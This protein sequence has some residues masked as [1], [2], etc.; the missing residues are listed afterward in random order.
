MESK[1]KLAIL[2]M[3]AGHPNQ[4]L[5]C[6]KEISDHYLDHLDYKIFDVRQTGIVPDL[7]YDIYISSGG[8]GNPLEGDGVWDVR[9][10]Q[11]LDD[12]WMH[13]AN[14]LNLRK[15]YL[16]LICHSFQI[17]SAHFRLG[18]ITRRRS[19]SFGIYPVHKTEYGKEEDI[20]EVLPD[21]F[22]VVDSRDWQLVQPDLAVFQRRGARVL[23]LEKIRDH[24][25]FER[26]IMMVR[27]SKEI[28]GTQFHPEA[29]AKGMKEHFQKEENKQKVIANFGEQK[30]EDMIEHLEDP[31]KVE[32]THSVILPDFLNNAIA[33]INLTIPV[34]K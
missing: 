12:L 25:A 31:D 33:K 7:S 24:V 29:D 22:H 34:N 8:P 13:N 9:F 28:V 16:F 23:V 19:T 27:F 11:L 26:A 14:P 17:A 18:E 4:G 15:K 2:D 20:L 21:P 5:R 32:A 3:N 10:C 6:I 1:L 30:Y